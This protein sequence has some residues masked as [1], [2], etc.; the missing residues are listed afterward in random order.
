MAEFSLEYGFSF[1][2]F[3]I[4][5]IYDSLDDGFFVN[6]ICE[7]FGF[8]GICKKNNQCFVLIVEKNKNVWY[9]FDFEENKIN[10]NETIP[11]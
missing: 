2:D 4:K 7:G 1:H 9:K 11:D 6:Q 8:L 3:S 5:D 10:F